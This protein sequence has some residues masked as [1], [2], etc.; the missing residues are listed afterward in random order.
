MVRWGVARVSWAAATGRFTGAVWCAGRVGPRGWPGHR[1][2]ANLGFHVCDVSAPRAWPSVMGRI[3]G[4][5]GDAGAWRHRVE[6]VVRMVIGQIGG[7][8]LKCGLIRCLGGGAEGAWLF[9][10]VERALAYGLSREG[11]GLALSYDA[12][13]AA[14]AGTVVCF[15]ETWAPLRPIARFG[16]GTGSAGLTGR[17]PWR[18]AVAFALCRAFRHGGRVR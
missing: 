7:W 18:N 6:R 3:A 5:G 12:G 13:R 14:L 17:L 9:G 1:R 16:T 2:A 4:A 15:G 11:H 10:G 8:V